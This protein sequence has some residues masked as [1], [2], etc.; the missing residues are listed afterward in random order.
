MSNQTNGV[1][2]S[3][4]RGILSVV[5]G[6]LLRY[7]YDA[8]L[9]EQSSAAMRK[10]RRRRRRNHDVESSMSSTTSHQYAAADFNPSN[11]EWTLF[12]FGSSSN[13]YSLRFR[14]LLAEFCQNHQHEVQCICVPNDADD[15]DDNNNIADDLLL[16]G[17]GFYKLPW[18]HPNRSALV[19]LLGVTQIPT[20]VVLSNHD[21]RR[22][23]D[24]GMA[25]IE[26][27]WNNNS[28]VTALFE[29]WRH[30]NRGDSWM[31]TCAIS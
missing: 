30:H 10:H 13:L 3:T 11:S 8:T 9:L 27:S 16:L 24:R 6:S 7:K 5:D 15:K 4:C 28:D 31:S 2:T 22:I 29:R 18:D 19:H 26:K 20:L 17:T 25:A 1:R 12:F 21:G 14:P 23:T